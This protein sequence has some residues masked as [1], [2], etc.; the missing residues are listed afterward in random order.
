MTQLTVLRARAPLP[1]VVLL[2]VAG[3]T[4]TAADTLAASAPLPA[5]NPTQEAAVGAKIFADHCSRC[6][7]AP[8]P[9]S[10]DGRSWRAI[11]LHMRVLGD[12]SAEE[13][14]RV[15]LFLITFNTAA[16]TKKPGVPAVR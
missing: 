9:A 16:M 2:L 13:Q 12:L 14:H 6:H 10:R 11:S 5:A 3:A 7:E 1:V 8:D 15:L 4:L